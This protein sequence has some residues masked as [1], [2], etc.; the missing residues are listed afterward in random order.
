M[1]GCARIEAKAETK[2]Q[3][4]GNRTKKTKER[5]RADLDRGGSAEDGSEAVLDLRRHRLQLPP[6]VLLRESPKPNVSYT[7][8]PH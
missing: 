8:K 1:L 6:P 3:R 2:K 7:P 4:E 5:G